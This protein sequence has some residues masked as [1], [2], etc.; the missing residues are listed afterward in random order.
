MKPK[1]DLRKSKKSVKQKDQTSVQNN[2]VEKHKEGLGEDLNHTRHNSTLA[3][4][5]ALLNVFKDSFSECF[6]DTLPQVIQQV[7]GHLFDRDFG[8]AFGSKPF[9]EAYSLRWSP[10]RALA[11]MDLVC[12]VPQISALLGKV[13]RGSTMPLLHGQASLPLDNAGQTHTS[14]VG[15]TS[16]PI[17]TS[18]DCTSSRITFACFGGGAGAEVMAFAGYMR[19]VLDSESTD[20]SGLPEDQ[21]GDDMPP[22][23]AFQNAGLTLRIV[24]MAE[25]ADVIDNL[26]AGATTIP[27]VSK[28]A[29]SG[30]KNRRGPLLDPL[31]FSVEFEQQ[32]IL[33]MEAEKLAKSLR[34]ST[35]ITLF[36]TLNELYAASM[37]KT[38]NFLLMLT[39][40]T[41]PGALLLVVDS[42]GSYS[43]VRVGNSPGT[44]SKGAETRYPMKWILDHTLLEASSTKSS[45][46]A[47]QKAHWEKLSSNDSKW[48]RLSHELKYPLELEDMRYQYHLYRRV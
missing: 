14:P 24:D 40:F 46:K 6:S 17:Q 33:C 7:K 19:C 36:F 34:G 3:L 5:Q 42:P 1:G 23:G 2:V 18:Q 44:D 8:K 29:A 15:L 39:F 12:G 25:W 13:L 41:Q 43:S 21:S 35:L 48:F 22:S 32:D 26:H 47:T 27:P 38:T 20:T 28:Y 11:Y 45:D 30:G 4:Q 9:L 37:S 31:Q 10:G 16:A